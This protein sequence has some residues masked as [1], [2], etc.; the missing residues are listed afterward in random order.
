MNER[1]CL[2]SYYSSPLGEIVL[3]SDGEVLTGLWF[4]SSRFIKAEGKVDNNNKIFV[5]TK[6]WLDRYFK[7]KNPN[8]KEIPYRL[9]G[10]EFSK[11]VWEILK[12][13]PY[14]KTI[15]YGEIAKKLGEKMSAQAVGHAVGH[16][17]L[18]IIV[19][20]HRVMGANNNLTGYG[21][22]LDKKIGLLKLEGIDV[23]SLYVPKKV[24]I[25]RK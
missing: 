5:I 12:A 9:E 15:T 22:G 19:P 23:K 20:C 11:R 10:S 18:S 13:I 6:N 3:Q 8:P 21:G 2:K 1:I 25:N 14:G 17:P 7:G 24:M 4:L 16:N